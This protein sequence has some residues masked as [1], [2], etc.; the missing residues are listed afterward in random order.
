MKEKILRVIVRHCTFSQASKEKHRPQGFDRVH[1]FL[2]LLESIQSPHISLVVLLDKHEND[3][4]HFV[5]EIVKELSVPIEIV[6][7]YC[8]SEAASFLSMLEY[9]RDSAWDAQDTVVFLE[10]DYL[11][12][13]TWH[14]LIEEGLEIADYVSLYDHPDK[15]SNVYKSVRCL[16]FKQPKRHWRT[17]PSTTNSY[18]MKKQT[19]MRDMDIHM[20]FSTGVRVSRDHEKFLE[21][22]NMG[23]KLIT[24]VPAAWSHEE[25]DMQCEISQ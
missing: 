4:T 15:Y 17:T 6:R 10:D 25:L 20:H 18:A 13:P 1:L 23:R 21:L 19:L 7:K 2:K 14:S 22:W 11:V 24:C 12:S 16:L 9:V 5:E 8:G 3:S